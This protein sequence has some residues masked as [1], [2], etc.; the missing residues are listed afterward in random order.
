M[1]VTTKMARQLRERDP[2]CLHCGE[3]FALQV[4]HRRN[5][6]MGSSKLLDRYDNLLRIC[7]GLNYAMEAD[8]DIAAD[9]RNKGWKLSQWD[10][11]DKPVFDN[12]LQKWFHLNN[13]GEKHEAGEDNALF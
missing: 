10:S 11:F 13:E 1:A 4:H 12:V 7:A 3:D 9:A 6:G 5:R 2:Y 8:A